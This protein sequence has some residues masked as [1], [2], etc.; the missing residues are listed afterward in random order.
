MNDEILREIK[1]IH[2]L[3][4]E[5]V[6]HQIGGEGSWQRLFN[7]IMLGVISVAVVYIAFKI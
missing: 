7:S 5:Y 2:S 3:I 1:G 6:H 4:S